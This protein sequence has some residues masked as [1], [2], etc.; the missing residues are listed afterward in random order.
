MDTKLCFHI[1]AILNIVRMIMGMQIYLRIKKFWVACVCME[2][3]IYN[4]ILF[5]FLKGD[6]CHL[7]QQRWTQRHYAKWNTVDP[8]RKKKIHHLSYMWSLKKKTNM[9]KQRVEQW[10]PVD[11]EKFEMGRYWSRYTKLQ[12]CSMGK[13][14]GLVWNLMLSTGNK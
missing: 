5:N 1:L 10:L 7:P 13:P 6:L 8:E 14:R 3:V 2:Y 12:L 4:G 11:M 9:W